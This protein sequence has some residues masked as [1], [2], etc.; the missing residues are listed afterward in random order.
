VSNVE[1][2][3]PQYGQESREYILA[4]FAVVPEEE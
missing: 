3:I 4:I 2:N 1:A